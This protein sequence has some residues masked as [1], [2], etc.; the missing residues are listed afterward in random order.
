MARIYLIVAAVSG[1]L[2]VMLGAFGAHSLKGSIEEP[3]F[4]AYQTAVQYQFYHTL[5]LLAVSILLQTG[6]ASN[7]DGTRLNH[8]G[9]NT[10]WLSYSGGLLLL[11]LLLFCGSLYAL[12]LG[13]PKFVGAITPLGGLSFLTAWLCLLLSAWRQPLEK[14]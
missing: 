2:T 7:S 3:L 12:A 4:Q 5:A 1:L 9:L 13:A 11:G 6:S 10:K 14:L 8:K